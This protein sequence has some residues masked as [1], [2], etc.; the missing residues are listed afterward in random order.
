MPFDKIR[1]PSDGQKITIL[2][3]NSLEIPDNPII[4][5][6]EGDGVGADIWKTTQKI[7]D[8]AINKA[9]SGTRSI[10]WMEIFAGEKAYNYYNKNNDAWL[11][12]ETLYALEE[13]YIAIIGPI[14]NPLD[15]NMPILKKIHESI[16][17][18]TSITYFYCLN[19]LQ[20]YFNYSKNID[21]T[22]FIENSEGLQNNIEFDQLNPNSANLKSI[23]KQEEN[24]NKLQY[25][26]SSLFCTFTISKD[27]VYRLVRTAIQFAI[28]NDKESVTIIHRENLLRVTEGSFVKWSY[29]L[30][31]TEYNAKQL[32]GS[33]WSAIK[34]PKNG[35]SIIVKDIFVDDFI[36]Q[37]LIHPAEFSVLVT[38]NLNGDFISSVLSAGTGFIG[39]EHSA[40]INYTTG[41]AVFEANQNTFPKFTGQNK[42]NPSSMILSAEHML[43]YIGWKEPAKLIKKGFEATISSKIFTYDIARRTENAKEVK[44]SE[45]G[46]E[47]I[48]NM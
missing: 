40:K 13:F 11:P 38:A 28:D 43:N 1:V 4:L 21:I 14:R 31:K 24:Q 37:L 47:I 5:Y 2:P 22:L 18:Y 39:M 34:N 25:I 20:T 19:G 45:F 35:K 23:L 10:I 8:S 12:M 48:K 30:S 29:L 41:R 15:H 36:K 32:D 27:A 42:A 17:L 9:Y 6:I 46:D 33:Y 7:I 16:D 3:D 26:D 44:C